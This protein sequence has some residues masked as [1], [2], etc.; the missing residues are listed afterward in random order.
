MPL[1]SD[2]HFPRILQRP[3]SSCPACRGLKRAHT[4]EGDCIHTPASADTENQRR[5]AL[6]QGRQEQATNPNKKRAHSVRNVHVDEPEQRS[7]V[8]KVAHR[9]KQ[10]AG[11][12][13]GF[14]A[15]RQT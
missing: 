2:L 10:V 1:Q 15:P 13:L 7:P 9:A 6:P 8:R 11:K 5:D 14:L 12:I 3:V 4:R